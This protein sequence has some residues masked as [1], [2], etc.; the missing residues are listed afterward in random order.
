MAIPAVNLPR[1]PA[2]R[3]YL[4]WSLAPIPAQY[5]R[6]SPA[7]RSRQVVGTST[8]A[9]PSKR[10]HRQ[11]ERRLETPFRLDRHAVEKLPTLELVVARSVVCWMPPAQ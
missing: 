11:L 9:R 4:R 7:V 6:L 3:D 8:T 2:D 1:R 5:Q 10:F